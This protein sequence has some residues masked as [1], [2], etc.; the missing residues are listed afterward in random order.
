VQTIY[1][2]AACVFLL[3]LDDIY[4]MS[5]RLEW[6]PRIDGRIMVKDMTLAE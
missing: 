2:E 4:G 1:D 5:Q 3:N 6:Q